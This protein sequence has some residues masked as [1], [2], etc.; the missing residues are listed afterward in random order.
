MKSA[1]VELRSGGVNSPWVE[2][3]EDLAAKVMAEKLEAEQAGAGAYT[4]T[5][6]SST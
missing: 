3:E 4:R 2:D 6:F 1:Y 5:P